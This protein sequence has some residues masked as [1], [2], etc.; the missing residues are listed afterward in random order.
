MHFHASAEDD[1][2]MAWQPRS[3][4]SLRLARQALEEEQQV[5]A[6]LAPGTIRSEG[7][8]AAKKAALSTPHP[9]QPRPQARAGQTRRLLGNN[10][11]GTRRGGG[12]GWPPQPRQEPINYLE[13]RRNAAAKQ[14]LVRNRSQAAVAMEIVRPAS[15]Q[16]P[17]A[18]APMMPIPVEEL[19]PAVDTAS[20]L[21]QLHKTFRHKGHVNGALL[22]ANMQ[23]L[24]REKARVDHEAKHMNQQLQEIMV[25]IRNNVSLMYK[26]TPLFKIY[27]RHKYRFGWQ[28]WLAYVSWHREEMAR[29][30]LLWPFAVRIQ[31]LFRKKRTQW[32]RAHDRLTLA[33]RQWNAAIYLQSVV[34]QWLAQRER[35]RLL[36]S[37]IAARLQAGWRGRVERRHV[38]Q[39]LKE[40]I[41]AMLRSLSPTGN[42]HRLHEVIQSHPEL[43]RPLNHMLSLIEET[44][45]AVE[46]EH[47]HKPRHAAIAAR[48]LTVPVEATRRE[49]FHAVHELSRVIAQH[50]DKLA[51][52]RAAHAA[53]TKAKHDQ[54]TAA[55]EAVKWEQWLKTKTRLDRERELKQMHTAEL[56]SKEY[57]RALRTIHSDHMLRARM[58][59]ERREQAENSLMLIEEYELRYVI[60][61]S[62]RR[63]LDERKRLKE[64]HKKE[65]FLHEQAQRQLQH[66]MHVMNEDEVKR[67]EMRAR[68]HA[69]KQA[70]L[71]QWSKLTQLEQAELMRRLQEREHA[72]EAEKQRLETLAQAQRAKEME[73]LMLKEQKRLRKQQELARELQER[74][75]MAEVDK[76]SRK[77]QYE[78]RRQRHALDWQEKREHELVRYSLDPLHFARIEHRKVQEEKE[79]RER[80]SMKHEDELM[81]A[82]HAQERKAQ[83]FA[84]CRAR[85]KQ[86]AIDDAKARKET[87]LMVI[88]DQREKDR[89]AAIKKADEYK[90][91]LAAMQRV[92]ESDRRRAQERLDEARHRKEMHD[93]EIAQRRTAQAIELREWI[94]EKSELKAM[95]AEEQAQRAVELAIAKREDKRLRRQRNL[96][97]MRE[98]VESRERHEMEQEGLRLQALLW[99]PADAAAFSHVVPLYDSFLRTNAA[100]LK[101]WAHI[102][103]P[104]PF[105]LDYAAVAKHRAIE[106][107]LSIEHVPR[108]KRKPRKFFYHEFFENDTF[109][110]NTNAS[111]GADAK[112]SGAAAAPCRARQRWRRLAFHFLG[113]ARR[114]DA[115][116]QGQLLL[117]N[118]QYEEAATHLVAAWE[119]IKEG[120]PSVATARLERQ[121]GRCYWRWWQQSLQAVLLE[122]ALSF[123]HR[124]GSHIQLLSSPAF[125][126]EVAHVLEH[127][128]KHRQA[129]EVLG[130][131][132]TCFPR[133]AQLTQVI[134]RGAINMMAL[135]MFQQCREYLLYTMDQQPFG[136][137]DVDVLFIVA[138]VLQLEGPMRKKLCSVAYEDTF[139]KN[140]RDALYARYPT[141][142]DWVKDPDTWRKHGDR[143]FALHEFV[144][145]K[146]AYLVMQRR[147]LKSPARV[148]QDDDWMRMARTAAVLNDRAVCDRAVRRWLATKSY[149][150]RVKE[151]YYRWP[152]V[153]WKLLGLE[154]PPEVTAAIARMEQEE[155][156]ARVQRRREIEAQK[157]SVLDRR[158]RK[159]ERLKQAWAESEALAPAPAPPPPQA[160]APAPQMAPSQQN[161]ATAIWMPE[162]VEY[163]WQL[164]VD[165]H[166]GDVYYW[167]EETN[168]VSWD[169]PT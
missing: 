158:S 56:E 8:L 76:Q 160:P 11:N 106:D 9:V 110:T 23:R 29:F 96:R 86:K 38:K 37:R 59:L 33:W 55:E 51:R 116:R 120:N 143:C 101:G 124:A 102:A 108:K 145:A 36:E 41:R 39:L 75:M 58:R 132:I 150:E 25:D 24:Y 61:E 119:A 162:D 68:R 80:C 127:A 57:A 14:A 7:Q 130:G 111:P 72:K 149:E 49:L 19:A 128:R 169:V 89:V 65:Q 40:R 15:P 97:M 154:V 81:G 126:Q 117:L 44:Y 67:N 62:R 34:R 161:N 134:F 20:V 112:A 156:D 60:A 131:I 125:L 1:D 32:Q 87:A 100:I 129:A 168:A 21:E 151:Q 118:G 27:A 31:R 83:Y 79:R 6:A 42:L 141:W 121:L 90:R 3:P 88:E 13:L 92:A 153:R 28:R 78:L 115:A 137:A 98:D 46:M 140:K 133:Y 69:A 104:P 18:A 73:Q 50:N 139:R 16:A 4:G 63:E 12:P 95:R 157:Q 77:W 103:L 142:Q 2:A 99:S 165:D 47:V 144:L 155:R 48:H 54:Q 148:R 105:E 93:E 152:L 84:A 107:I 82:I 159:A 74:T 43:L 136:L 66:V 70:E 109:T 35:Q 167:N 85:Q 138:R 26:F 53:A 10:D 71:E 123:F 94:H 113:A 45:I 163:P 164:V 147:L 122:R 22:A 135:Q 52:A 91:T 30:V 146:D 166:T 5:L 17:V 114:S 64:V